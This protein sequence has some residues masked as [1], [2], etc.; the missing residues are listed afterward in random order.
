MW[1]VDTCGR[2]AANQPAMH[3]TVPQQKTAQS[4]MSV[5]LVFRNPYLNHSRR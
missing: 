3:R 2:N 5:V 4:Q 1:E